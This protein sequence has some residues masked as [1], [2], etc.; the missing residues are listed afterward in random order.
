MS[1]LYKEIFDAYTET[2]S[3]IYSNLKKSE[4]EKGVIFNNLE[5]REAIS[6]VINK[7][8]T[9]HKKDLYI[10]YIDTYTTEEDTFNIKLTG[11]IDLVMSLETRLKE[12]NKEEIDAFQ[13]KLKNNQR[14]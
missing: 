9:N 10:Y 5:K 12:I 14:V 7:L 4:L 3:D 13:L 11:L 2:A 8:S 6:T 1:L